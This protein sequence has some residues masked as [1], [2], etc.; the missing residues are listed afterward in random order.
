[1]KSSV[2]LRPATR[3]DIAG[4]QRVRHSVR[5]NRLT[6]TVITDDDVERAIE[7]L[8]RGWVVAIEQDVVAF[9]I[10]RVTDGNL[11][12]L[13][14]EPDNEGRGYGRRLH[15]EV[16]GWLGAQGVKRLWLTTQPGTRAE[17]FYQRAGWQ[18]R[19]MTAG[20]ERLFEFETP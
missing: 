3:A 12:A 18:D 6:S 2:V 13:F 20:G 19:G 10:G 9:A 16:V 11:W 4:I 1:M 5:E 7:I 17:R 14:V 15:D 8:G